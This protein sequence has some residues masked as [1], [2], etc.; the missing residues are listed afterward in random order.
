MVKSFL[1]R[2]RANMS[3][4]LSVILAVACLQGPPEGYWFSDT[5]SDDIYL[6]KDDHVIIG[7]T[8][9]NRDIIKEFIVGLRIPVN[10]FVCKYSSPA[11][12]D[13]VS[14]EIK[15][16]EEDEYFILNYRTQ[17]LYI[18]RDFYEFEKKLDSLDLNRNK[19]DYSRFKEIRMKYRDF[20]ES[21]QSLLEIKC[22]EYP[23]GT[24]EYERSEYSD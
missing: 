19:L 11:A 4:A 12:G 7:S 20:D 21:K 3:V 2:L 22:S 10:F 17:D 15:L 9:V 18:F 13:F 1:T 16:T 14:S 23:I 8:I 5:R 24:R 6:L